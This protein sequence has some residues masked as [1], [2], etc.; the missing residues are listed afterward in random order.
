[1]RRCGLVLLALCMWPTLGSC[2][3]LTRFDDLAFDDDPC[4]PPPPEGCAGGRTLVYVGRGIRLNRADA[5]GRRDGFDLDATADPICGEDDV[6]SPAGET[7]IDTNLS[8]MLEA[9]EQLEGIDL[10]A[11]V[12]AQARR[13]EQLG[14]LV[15]AHI[16]STANDDCVEVAQR[17]ALLVPGTSQADLDRDGDGRLDAGLTL[18]YLAASQTSTSACIV[19]GVLHARFASQSG[20]IPGSTLEARAHDA[21]VRM[22]VPA[23]GD[24]AFP[25]LGGS[26]EVDEV[27]GGLPPPVADYLRLRADI[28]PSRRGADDCDRISFAMSIEMVPA[29]LG[30]LRSP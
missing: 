18:D 17:S 12:R 20:I 30:S 9:Y 26:V 5:E 25:L 19:D 3:A 1:M 10:E 2:T 22:V 29:V 11:L 13:G 15:F 7:G 6:V 16:D 24:T 8:S 23:D 28:H 4:P 21:R 14:L 27:S